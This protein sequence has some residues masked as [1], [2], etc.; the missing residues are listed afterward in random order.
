[1]V[2]LVVLML[3]ILV[4]AGGVVLYVAYPHRGE[5]VPGAP[6][7]GEAIRKGVDGVGDL[8]DRPADE[9]RREHSQ[10]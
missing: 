1:M 6:W 3:A 7:L 4:L 10:R 5:D 2:V 8:L 9:R